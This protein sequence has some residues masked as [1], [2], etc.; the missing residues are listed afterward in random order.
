MQFKTSVKDE[1]SSNLN[2]TILISNNKN[3]SSNEN[4][5][6]VERDNNSLD[7]NITDCFIKRNSM[8]IISSLPYRKYMKI[9][10]IQIKVKEFF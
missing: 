6:I 9:M 1:T 10:T 2:E 5:E 7:K 3:S 4:I 8:M